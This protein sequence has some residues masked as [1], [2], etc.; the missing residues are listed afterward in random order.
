MNNLPPKY[1]P[2]TP[3]EGPL[4]TSRGPQH[5][6]NHPQATKSTF[7]KIGQKN[8]ACKQLKDLSS[9]CQ[10]DS[11]PQGLQAPLGAAPRG[12]KITHGHKI[13]IF[14]DRTMKFG[15]QAVERLMNCILERFHS[16]G[17]LCLP[18]GSPQGYQNHPQ[19]IKS[20][21]LEAE[22]QEAEIW[23]TST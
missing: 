12:S 11:K 8:L 23:D 13:H 9:V 16:L 21:F 2:G 17:A 19:A 5:H 3:L 20:T 7:L 15:I 18:R 1:V 10:R 14:E 6:Q 4:G 22:I